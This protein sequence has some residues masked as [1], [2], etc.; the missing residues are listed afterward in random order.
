MVFLI[1]IIEQLHRV[2]FET[3]SLKLQ[4]FIIHHI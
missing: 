3:I 1:A 4:R 2:N